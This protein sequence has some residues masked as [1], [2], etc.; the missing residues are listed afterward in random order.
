MNL[1]K[2]LA[3][4]QRDSLSVLF[5]SIVRWDDKIADELSEALMTIKA[6]RPTTLLPSK[7]AMEKRVTQLLLTSPSLVEYLSQCYMQR[8][9]RLL[10]T[11][12][13]LNFCIKRSEI[14]HEAIKSK[15]TE[16]TCH[17]I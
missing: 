9:C 15:S 16:L 1:P 7:M 13:D 4:V 14:A 6:K 5:D 10:M 2:R 8:R 3:S 12:N 17:N 11:Y